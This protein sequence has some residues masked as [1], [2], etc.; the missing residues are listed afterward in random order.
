LRHDRGVI[1]PARNVVRLPADAALLSAI[2]FRAIVSMLFGV[3]PF[4]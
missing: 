3:G 2:G 1:E 4:H